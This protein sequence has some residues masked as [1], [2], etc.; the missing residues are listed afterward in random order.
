MG[1]SG[2]DVLDVLRAT[3]GAVAA[4]LEGHLDWGPSGSREGQY[5]SDLAADAAAL[6]V[7]TSEGLGVMSEESGGRDLDADVVVVLDPLDGSSNASRG[8]AWYATSL[9]AVDEVGPLA[10]LVRNVVT[11]TC[12]EAVR[13]GGAFRDGEPIAPSGSTELETSIVGLSGFPAENLGWGQFRALGAAALDLCLVA[14]GTLDAYVDCSR[15]AHGSWDYL[16]GLLICT[17]AGASMVDAHDRDL[18]VVDHHARRTP[19]AAA[20][21]ELLTELVRARRAVD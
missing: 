15:D 20:T 7:L 19:V 5:A 9:C 10:A 14:D 16:G 17:E 21:D 13:G 3:A 1:R 2:Q 6:E 12:W 4:E 8:I 18:V 11:G